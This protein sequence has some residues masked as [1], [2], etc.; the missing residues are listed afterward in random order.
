MPRILIVEDEP[1]LAL[2]LEE[3]LLDAGFAIVGIAGRLEAALAYIG[4]GECDAAVLDANLAGV[5]AGPAASELRRLG[6]PFIV[7][8]GYSAAQQSAAFG[9]AICFQKPCKPELMIEAL[10]RFFVGPP[11]EI[12]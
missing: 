5:S 4:E 8:S 11:L 6:I 12:I 7:V 9:G 2:I 10:N 3:V 1:L